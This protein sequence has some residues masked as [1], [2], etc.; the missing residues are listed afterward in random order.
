MPHIWLILFF[1]EAEHISSLMMLRDSRGRKE[2]E[3]EEVVEEQ[4]E[5][6]VEELEEEGEEVREELPWLV[7]IS[8]Q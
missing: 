8:W 3:E 4:E 2:V 6:V 7:V 5:E 1:Q